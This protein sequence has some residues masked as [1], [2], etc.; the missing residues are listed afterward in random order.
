MLVVPTPPVAPVMAMSLHP[1]PE[2]PVT[3]PSAGGGETAAVLAAARERLFD[4][5]EG[6]AHGEFPPQPH[7]PAICRYCAYAAVCRKDYAGD[8]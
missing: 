7:D 3:K 1:R 5:V 8:D 4:V 2:A 6:I